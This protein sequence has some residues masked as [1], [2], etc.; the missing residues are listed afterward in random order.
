MLSEIKERAEKEKAARAADQ[1]SRASM[2]HRAFVQNDSGEK[3]LAQW[4][5]MYCMTPISQPDA[6]LFQAG[7]AEGR[8][9]MV[10]EI[11]EHIGLINSQ[12]G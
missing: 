11:L 5:R 8:R 4:V 3:I 2:Y 12:E 6:T 1:Q 10:K 7:I 9:L